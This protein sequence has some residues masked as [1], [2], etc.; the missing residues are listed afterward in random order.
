MTTKLGLPRHYVEKIVDAII[1][2]I[3]ESGCISRNRLIDAGVAAVAIATS[4]DETPDPLADKSLMQAL[5][6]TKAE[7][8][9]AG[10]WGAKPDWVWLPGGGLGAHRDVR[11]VLIDERTKIAEKKAS[12][13]DV[14]PW[15]GQ[16]KLSW[17]D[18]TSVRRS[19][20]IPISR[21]R[22]TIRNHEEHLYDTH[23][24]GQAAYNKDGLEG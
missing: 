23:W 6:D 16:C 20:P 22:E 9:A 15:T 4:K 12:I 18:S 2:D 1:N 21:I 5:M 3:E 13:C 24:K 19:V 11:S 14:D 17:V 7:L 10:Q 8:Q